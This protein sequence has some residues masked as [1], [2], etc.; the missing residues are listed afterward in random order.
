ML[1]DTNIVAYFFRGDSRARAY[2]RH[3]A[4][5]TRYI[6]FVT[7]GEL[8]QWLF[9]R[10]FSEANRQR[11]LN[12]IAQHVVVP[13][14]DRLVWAWAELTAERRKTGRPMSLQDAWIAATALRHGMPLVTHNR[15]HFEHVP[16]L[17]VISEA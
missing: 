1:L 4:A 2:E 14:D 7:Q 15:E 12:Y 10:P 9:L 5:K 6:A 13:Y 3:L 16:G 8:Y 17:T 11:L